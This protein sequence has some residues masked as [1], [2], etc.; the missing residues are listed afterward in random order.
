M[1]TQAGESRSD[2]VDARFN[3]GLRRGEDPASMMV[4]GR[5]VTTGNSRWFQSFCGSCSHNFR[6]GDPVLVEVGDRGEIREVRHDGRP[7]CGGS[8]DL[9]PLDPEIAGRFFAGIETIDPPVTP[10]LERLLPGHPMLQVREGVRPKKR[11]FHCMVCNNTFRPLELVV[12]CVCS[13]QRKV[14][15]LTV[16]R[17]APHNLLCYDDLLSAQRGG[18]I[19]VCPMNY[20]EIR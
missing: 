20:R 17:D 4:S 8:D 5:A 10:Y 3:D 11:R 9:P 14:C 7:W 13:P 19:T 12:I 1:T 16:H 2:A 15:A 6:L 18:R